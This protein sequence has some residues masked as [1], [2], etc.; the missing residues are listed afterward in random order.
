MTRTTPLTRRPKASRRPWARESIGSSP[1]PWIW[2]AWSETSHYG[3]IKIDTVAPTTQISAPAQVTNKTFTVSWSG[4]DAT[5]GVHHYEVL[6]RYDGRLARLADVYRVS[7]SPYA[8]FTGQNGHRYD[9]QARAYDQAGNV[10]TWGD[11]PQAETAV[12]TVDFVA[13]GLEVTQ[14]VQD[15]NNNVPLV[16]GKRTFARFYVRS[17]SGDHGPVR[18][19]L[20]LYRDGQFVRRSWRA[21]RMGASRCARTR[22]VASLRTASIS[23]CPRPG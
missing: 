21:I 23:T 17:A 3:P 11:S 4:S 20:N 9:F 1:A 19:Q 10:R 14:A 8:S 2:P 22:I 7:T 13:F 12:A 18:A 15:M 16:E 6:S 5:S